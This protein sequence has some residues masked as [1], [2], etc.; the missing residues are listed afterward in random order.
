M[1]VALATLTFSSPH[2]LLPV[3]A[4][5]LVAAALLAWSYRRSSLTPGWRWRWWAA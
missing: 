5:V 4:V 3:G 1:S 2:W